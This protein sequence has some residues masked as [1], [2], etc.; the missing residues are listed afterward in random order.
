M[1]YPG[2]GCFRGVPV[3]PYVPRMHT[4]S[5]PTR[6]LTIT[7][8]PSLDLLF[9]TDALVLDDA[10]RMDDPRRRPGGQGIN[11]VRAA[12]ELG[13]TA[14]AVALL[15]GRT[16]REIADALLAE[17]VRL[18]D[19][20]AD[21]DT[22]TFVAVRTRADGHSLLLNA[23]G[24]ART[25]EDA[26]R[27]LDAAAR[28][29]NELHPRWLACCGSLPAGFPPDFYAEAASLARRHGV[30]VVVD[31][32][33][34]PLRRAAGLCDLLVPNQHEAT[35][36]LGTPVRSVDHAARAARLLVNRGTTAVAIT[37]GAEGAVF[38]CADGCWHAA[39]PAMTDG[40]AVG[41]GDAFL[42]ALLVNE[43]MAPAERLR[44]AVAAGAATLESEG[45]DLLRYLN[46]EA[47]R[48]RVEVRPLHL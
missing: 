31:C 19:V 14:T 1:A 10:N 24:P 27:L 38:A 43:D 30:R 34:E 3:V 8:N 25:H 39:P 12:R 41:A 5:L 26:A 6:L 9:E 18:I 40:S 13:G 45:A 37:L 28:A 7:P 44:T 17:G 32:D 33:G 35:R 42:A 29:L 21:D 22:R 48:E 46:T 15:G 4:T 47:I 20:R 36:L 23:R 2:S 11:V 16:G